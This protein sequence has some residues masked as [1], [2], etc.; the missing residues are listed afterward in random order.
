MVSSSLAL[1]RELY[2]RICDGFDC[3]VSS[4]SYE[5]DVSI[6]ETCNALDSSADALEI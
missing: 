5:L 2:V 6:C 4:V 3:V 1:C